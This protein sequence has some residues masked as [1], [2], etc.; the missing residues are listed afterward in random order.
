MTFWTIL[1]I[2]I[3]DPRLEGATMQIAYAT[4]A[5]CDAARSIVGDT[6]SY[7]HNMQCIVS[8]VPSASMRPRPR[9]TK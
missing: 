1:F 7:D 6:L 3:L 4:E 9:P 2:T 5:E 8:N